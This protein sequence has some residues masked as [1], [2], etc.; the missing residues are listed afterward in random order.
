[1][2]KRAHLILLV[3]APLATGCLHDFNDAAINGEAPPPTDDLDGF[4]I[5]L[6]D[7][8]TTT[9]VCAQNTAKVTDLLERACH[10]CHNGPGAP[11]GFGFIMDFNMLKTSRTF[12][13]AYKDVDGLNFRYLTPGHPEHSFIYVRAAS[14]PPTMPPPQPPADISPYYPKTTDLSVLNYWIT[15]CTF[16]DPLAG[17]TMDAGTS[18]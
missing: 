14:Y 17:T 2:Y 5:E 18:G 8:G 13:S 3:C 11:N 6:D 1:M 16:P 12:N 7:G 4:P 15:S 10:V 9:D